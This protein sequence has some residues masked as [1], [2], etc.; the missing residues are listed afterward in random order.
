MKTQR[1]FTLV[2]LLVVI[3]IIAVLISI[4]L[5]SLNKARESANRVV[6][7]SNLR[8]IGMATM[9]YTNAHKGALPPAVDTHVSST[10]RWARLIQPFFKLNTDY[11]NMA[12]AEDAA[13]TR[14]FRCPSDPINPPVS[15]S[16]GL[17]LTDSARCSYGWT[18]QVAVDGPTPATEGDNITSKVVT[19]HITQ[20]KQ[21][22]DTLLAGDDWLRWN[23]VRYEARTL[24]LKGA[25]LK[26]TT[27]QGWHD[28][29]GSNML[30]VDGHVAFD[31]YKDV[32][33]IG[34]TEGSVKYEMP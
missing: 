10:Y 28:D 14:Y 30:F 13:V 29:K 8:Q 33:L 25:E 18:R 26:N 4:L 34:G 11:G 24:G 23:N 15:S 6:C 16:T 20:I 5:P 2:E 1:A 22:A 7:A 19:Y 9:M 3:G 27:G 17:P 31:Q 12:G 32:R 21:S